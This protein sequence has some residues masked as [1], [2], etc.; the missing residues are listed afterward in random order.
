VKDVT[1]DVDRLKVFES[2][3]EIFVAD[4]TNGL[5]KGIAFRHLLGLSLSLSELVFKHCGEGEEE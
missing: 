1:A 4:G 5:G 3:F 2:R